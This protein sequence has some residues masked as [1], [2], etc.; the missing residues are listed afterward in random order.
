LNN[1][2]FTADTHFDHDNIIKYCKRSFNNVKEMNDKYIEEWNKIVKTNDYV[3]HLGDFAFKNH[4][5][6]FKRLNGKK[7]L[8]I[9]NHDKRE[10]FNLK[11]E[12]FKQCF[13]LRIGNDSVW[14]SHYSHRSWNKSCHGS[15]HFFGHTHGNLSDYGRST[16]V[17]VD[18]WGRPVSFE[19]LRGKLSNKDKVI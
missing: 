3:Y 4:D 2:F 18:V 11:W 16:D 15:Y 19:E 10:C 12:W 9:G 1:I 8:I 14:L 5:L 13:D 7:H 17:G 6:F